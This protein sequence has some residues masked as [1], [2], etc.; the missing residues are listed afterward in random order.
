[1]LF[2]R[3]Q[4][5][6]LFNIQLIRKFNLLLPDY[7]Y[8]ITFNQNSLI[9]AFP[10]ITLVI[11]CCSSGVSMMASWVSGYAAHAWFASYHVRC[12]LMKK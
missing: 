5:N 4:Y 6:V 8:Q 7:F 2:K 12:S 3:F 9:P 11:N 10:V 1:M